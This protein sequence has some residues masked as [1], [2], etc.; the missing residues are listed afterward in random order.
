MKFA[1]DCMLGK[2]A[3]WLR[4][5]GFDAAFFP[6][7]ADEEL[8]RLARAQG[9]VLLT[10][11]SALLERARDKDALF[12]TSDDW[13]HQID[14][15]L[16]RKNLRNRCNPYTRCLE[17]NVQLKPV[18]KAR[19]RNLVTPFVHERAREFSLCPECGRIF[20]KGSHHED[21][22]RMIEQILRKK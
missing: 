18:S 12:I 6:A 2:L 21:M 10:R 15:V 4:I 13:R 5:L 1:V 19:A 14:Q 16:D 8:L 20:W 11:D 17:C 7:I 22:R 3:K 9:R